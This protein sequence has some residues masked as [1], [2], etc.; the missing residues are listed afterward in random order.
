MPKSLLNSV[1]MGLCKKILTIPSVNLQ[2]NSHKYSEYLLL[3]TVTAHYMK[4][5]QSWQIH[6]A[7]NK[8]Y[9]Q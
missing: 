7:A 2:Y 3:Y 1:F 8:L 6:K 9:K 4:S 5:F